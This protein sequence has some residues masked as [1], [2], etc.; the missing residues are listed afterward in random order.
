MG[1]EQEGAS[2]GIPGLITDLIGQLRG[3][4]EAMEGMVGMGPLGAQAAGGRSVPGLR[5][6][7][8]PGALSAAQLKSVA[9]SVAAQRRSIEALQAQLSAFD[10]QLAVLERIMGPLAEWSRTYAELED[11]LLALGHGAGREDQPD[12]S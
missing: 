12:P 6:L 1:D 7:P 10:E 11:R 9:S 8:R 4:T 3:V 2:G 5:N